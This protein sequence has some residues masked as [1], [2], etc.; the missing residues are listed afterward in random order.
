MRNNY[1]PGKRFVR[2]LIP[3]V[4]GLFCSLS[5]AQT[6]LPGAAPTSPQQPSAP[7]QAQSGASLGLQASG[8]L[9]ST[10]SGP[11]TA[12][13]LELTLEDT[14][15][16]GLRYNLAQAEGDQTVR[17]QRARQLRELSAMLPTLAI[18]PSVSEQ[19]VNLASFGFSGFAGIPS[20]VGPFSVYDARGVLSQ[21][22]LNLHDLRNYRAARANVSAAEFSQRD[23]RE[24]VVVV[25]TGLYL[26]A[27]SGA[28]RSEAQQ[29][30]VNTAQA[31]YNQ[32][33]DRRAAG[34]VPGIDVLRAQVQL[35]AEQ[36]RLIA[37][38][39]EFDNQ[40]ISLARAIG[41]PLGQQFH[42]ADSTP[43]APLPADVTIESTLELAYKQRADY[44]AQQALVRAAEL[45]KSA[46]RAG[47][48]PTAAIDA[49]YGVIGPLPDQLHGSFSVAGSVNIPIFQGGRVRADVEE[50]DAVLRQRQAELDDLRG[51][52]E[53]DV[54]TAFNNV[55]SASRQ[56]EVAVQTV[57][58]ARQQLEQAQG[59]FAA[60]VTNNLEVIQAQQAVAAANENYISALYAFNS[61]K[62]QVVR[63][64][65][66]AEQ[67]ITNYVRRIK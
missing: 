39:G 65:G 10:Q 44:R 15:S 30:Q 58:L 13:T 11:A 34:T 37:L 16:R 28:A 8:L 67:S 31:A 33:L 43:Y 40:K 46:A 35:Q 62:T 60:G 32:A 63:A 17:I 54:R 19:Q 45:S 4:F 57:D 12:E 36:Q 49:N 42:L 55:R 2:T 25:V 23:I 20:V 24:Q 27:L 48:Y 7:V 47:R 29:A 61:A 59:R 38:A 1:V 41:L 5:R 50:T 53:A 22:V 18:R 14:I 56:V 51:R 66:D 6:P 3:A 26:Q 64:R 52:I 9:G 21:S